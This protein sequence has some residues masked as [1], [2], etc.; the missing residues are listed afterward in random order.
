MF[1]SKIVIW[2]LNI[3]LSNFSKYKINNKKKQD[4]EPSLLVG[5]RF[6]VTVL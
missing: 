3:Q 1:D 2:T 4:G 6:I 5:V